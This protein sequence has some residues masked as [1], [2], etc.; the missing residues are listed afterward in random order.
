M[1]E[2]QKECQECGWRGLTAELDEANADASGQTQI[3]CPDCGGIDVQD[4]NPA[5]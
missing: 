2:N 5:E 4:L 1:G 3:F